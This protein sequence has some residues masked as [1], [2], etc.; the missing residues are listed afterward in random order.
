M[1][2]RNECWNLTVI[3]AVLSLQ[4]GR[5]GYGQRAQVPVIHEIVDEPREQMRG[6]NIRQNAFQNG[7]IA[8]NCRERDCFCLG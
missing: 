3:Q 2:T 7:G 4:L 5:L 1:A 8:G 6:G